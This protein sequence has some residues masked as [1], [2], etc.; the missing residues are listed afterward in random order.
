MSDYIDPPV[1]PGDPDELSQDAFDYL[2]D[3]IAGYEANDNTLEA[4]FIMAISRIVSTLSDEVQAAL[5]SI[6]RYFGATIVGLQPIAPVNATATTTWTMVDTAGYTIPAGTNCGFQIT[7]D[8][9]IGFQTVDDVTV[10]PGSSVTATGGVLVQAVDAGDSSNDLDSSTFVLVDALSFV[11]TVVAETAPSGGVDGETDAQYIKRL[12]DDFQLFS[13]TLILGADAGPL[14]RSISGV[15]RA[16]G[17][18]NYNPA[19]GTTTNERMIAVAVIDVDG[20]PCSAPVKAAVLAY[21]ETLRET[22]FICNVFDPT[23]TTINVDF[24]YTVFS[25]YDPD[26]VLASALL[27]LGEYLSPANWGVEAGDDTGETWDNETVVRLGEVFSLLNAVPG[28]R[29]VNSL[30]LNG[31]T[32]DVTMAGVVALPEPGTLVGAL[33]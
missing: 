14:A 33:A 32:A 2:A 13:P 10:A 16:V 5:T 17:V 1:G 24:T 27:T 31:G 30:T 20:N 3:N 8:T 21:L 29:W 4:W 12:H 18:D 9:L 25:G 28:L 19:D 7:G 6:F 23:Y 15:F 22:N 11:D 26:V